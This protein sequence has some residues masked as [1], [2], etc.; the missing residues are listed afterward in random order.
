MGTSIITMIGVSRRAALVI[1][2][3]LVFQRGMTLKEAIFLVSLD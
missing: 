2:T 3:G 1:Y